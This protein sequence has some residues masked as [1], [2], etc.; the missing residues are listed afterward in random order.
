MSEYSEYM[1]KKCIKY[2]QNVFRTIYYDRTLTKSGEV[3]NNRIK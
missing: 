1:C 2:T 3:E